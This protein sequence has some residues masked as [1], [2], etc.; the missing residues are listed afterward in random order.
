MRFLGPHACEEALAGGELHQL[1]IAPSAWGRS[2]AL[3]AAAKAAGVLVRQEPADALD[4]RSGGQRHQGVV[5]EG[6]DFAYTPFETILAGV[7]NQGEAA[8]LLALDGVPDPHHL[9]AILRRD[10]PVIQ[11]G[12][13]LTATIFVMVNLAVDLLYAWFDPRIR[14][15]R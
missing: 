11:G 5:G 12:L 3:R 6:A 8:L 7:R 9:G 10:Y 4:R 15:G 13:L 1:W 14:Y 2:A